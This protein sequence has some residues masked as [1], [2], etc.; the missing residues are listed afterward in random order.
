MDKALVFGTKDCR[1]ESCQ[2]HFLRRC[3]LCC[4]LC[5]CVCVYVCVCV[6]VFVCVCLYF[7]TPFVD[8]TVWPSGLR[9]WLKAP[10]RK[11]VGSNPTAVILLWHGFAQQSLS[12]TKTTPVGFEPT[13]GDPIGLAG[14]RLS[15]SAKVS[16]LAF[17]ADCSQSIGSHRKIAKRGFDPRTFGLW[18]QHANHCATSLWM[19]AF[20]AWWLQVV[21]RS[22]TIMRQVRIELTTLGLWDLR[23]A[24]CATAACFP[25]AYFSYFGGLCLCSC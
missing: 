23:A 20:A 5:V 1:F 19:L 10:V 8:K 21:R 18:A 22:Q 6:C 14:R 13:R 2:D 12:K 15:H 4:K 3:C 9:R 11:G 25:M 17:V 16:L 24:N 7:R